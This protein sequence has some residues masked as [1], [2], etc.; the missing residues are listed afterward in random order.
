MT[1]APAV[2][3]IGA[4]Q[5]GLSVGYYLSRRG[6]EPRRDVLIVDRGPTAGGA[7]QHR[8]D[9]LRLGD[10]HR[11]ADLPRMAESGAS[12]A[13]APA[14]Q[15][16]SAVVRHRYARYEQHYGLAVERPVDVTSVARDRDGSFRVTAAD[17]V[18][19]WGSHSAS[20]R[21][22]VAAVGTWRQPRLPTVP[23]AE[24]FHGVQITTPQFRSPEDFR[25]LRVGIV[26]G[27]ASAL[28]FLREL[29][30]V[31]SSLHWF[32]RRPVAFHG[33][34][35]GLGE[36]LGRE[37][38]RLQ[39]AAAR[40]GRPLPSIVSTTGM[41]LTPRLRRMQDRGLLERK[42]LFARVATDGAVLADGT[43]LALDAI[44]WALGFEADLGP[45]APLGIDARS[46]VRVE[47]GHVAAVPGLF[48][49]GYGPQA[50]TLSAE[51]GARVIARDAHRYLGSGS[52]PPGSS[53]SPPA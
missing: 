31:A 8:W 2:L 32:T 13:D 38:V 6:L 15:P 12:F 44:I 48:L 4:G 21:V 3:V 27:G 19:A 10:A 22:V 16:A 26:G 40:E 29:D 47:R 33:R 9:T 1:S 20:F 45:L 34:A 28:G 24:D 30:G 51:R 11:I 25:G 53:A 14:D 49:A 35:E 39:D 41:P 5:A 52:W 43:H 36:E 7:W 37:S 46:G 17:A 18:A 50:S 23:G 42:P